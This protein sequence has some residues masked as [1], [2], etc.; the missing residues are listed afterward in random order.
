MKKTGKIV[1]TILSILSFL[2]IAFVGSLYYIGGLSHRYYSQAVLNAVYIFCA[3]AIL[4]LAVLILMFVMMFRSKPILRRICTV[5]L[6]ALIPLALYGSLVGS[7]ILMIAGPNGCSYTEDIANYGKYDYEYQ[8][9]Y[10]PDAI[11]GDMTVVKYAYFYKYLDTDQIDIYLEV[12]FSDRETMEKYLAEAKDA[13]SK[14]GVI[15]YP[16]PYDP[17]YTDIIR[18]D[19]HL[20][21]IYF[22]CYDDY[23]YVSMGQYSTTYSYEELTIIYNY[24][25]I[26]SDIEIGND[27]DQGEYYPKYLERFGVEWDPSNNFSYS[28]TEE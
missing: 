7:A 15:T 16:N 24:T 4:V 8:P 23:K 3:A 25:S 6:I 26:G 9:P 5:L 27:P 20:S 10:F 11:T 18:K 2:S 17:N 1:L 14:D 19:R 21:S 13:L 12:K 22:S 28:Y